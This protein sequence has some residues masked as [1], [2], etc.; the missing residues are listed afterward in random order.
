MRIAR[1]RQLYKSDMRWPVFNLYATYKGRRDH[2]SDIILSQLHQNS[3]FRAF[4]C[5]F[6][7]SKGYEYPFD[8]A[9]H[10]FSS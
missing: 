1:N 4:T 9:Y 2:S 3:K 6:L 10:L 7:F 5:Q 8:Q